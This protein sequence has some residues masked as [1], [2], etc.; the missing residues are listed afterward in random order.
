MNEKG[1]IHDVEI[2]ILIIKNKIKVKELPVKWEHKSG[3]KVNI[4]KDSFVMFL[5]LIRLK[6]KYKI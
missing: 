3:S 5:T 2:L 6:I 4:I 1:Y